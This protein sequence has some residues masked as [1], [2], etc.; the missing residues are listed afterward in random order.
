[1]ID[2]M[3]VV[4]NVQERTDV[5]AVEVDFDI[6]AKATVVPMPGVWDLTEPVDVTVTAQDGETIAVYTVSVDF[7]TPSS[8]SELESILFT[9]GSQVVNGVPR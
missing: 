4:I 9:F 2:F 1:M 6:P 7:F 3:D 8:A 5:S